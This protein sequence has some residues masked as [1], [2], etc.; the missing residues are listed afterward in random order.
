MAQ[1]G[2]VVVQVVVVGGRPIEIWAM[3][4]NVCCLVC[5]VKST[6]RWAKRRD[7]VMRVPFAKAAEVLEQKRVKNKKVVVGPLFSV[8]SRRARNVSKRGRLALP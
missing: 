2:E 7:G 1:G 6:M 3:R 5:L 8:G 4:V